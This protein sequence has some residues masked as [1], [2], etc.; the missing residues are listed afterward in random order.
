MKNK[1]FLF[2]GLCALLCFGLLSTAAL[3]VVEPTASFYVA[4]YAGVLSDDT[5]QYII[6]Q[7]EKLL[8][9]TGGEIVVVAVD[10][11]D[12]MT[13]GDYA[14][15]VAENWGGIGDKE[16]DNGFLLVYAVGENK[17]RAMAGAG[18]E[19]ALPASTIEGYLEDCFYDG[20]DAGEYDQATRDF[21]DAIYGWY[22]SYYRV[23]SS[24][25]GGGAVSVPGADKD[26]YY[27]EAHGPS[28]AVTTVVGSVATAVVILVVVVLI[29]AVCTFDGLRYRRYRRR[30]MMP[31]M[32]PPPYLYRPFLFG[33]PHRHR[34]P[35]P[36]RPPRGPGG[37]PP[38]GMGGGPRPGGGSYRP[39]R[40]GGSFRGGGAGRGGGFSGGSFGGGSFRGGG[41]GFR[42]GG[43]GR[44]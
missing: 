11:M 42:G 34:P 6:D 36:P 18:L 15:A 20:Y 31:G 3:A 19:R 22:E 5:E 7:N 24:G 9:A 1:R 25:D 23:S 12:G 30:Y 16:L 41:G 37:R 8:S 38:G 29:I 27:P 39:P 4:D 21:F 32:P 17:V 28:T 14:M 33:R 13:S 43:A 40:G 10:F 35:P 2:G 26:F 44:G